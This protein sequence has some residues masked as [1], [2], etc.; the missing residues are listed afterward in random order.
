MPC[1]RIDF[2]KSELIGIR[3]E[4]VLMHLY[5]KVLGC[6]VDSIPATYFGLLLCVELT[7]KSL[8]NPIIERIE[9][10]LSLWKANNICMG[11]RV[12]LIKSVLANLPIYFMFVFN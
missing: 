6:K 2:Y 5:A 4:E 8:W 7:N 9:S 11:G 3:V 10:K 1:L 12:T